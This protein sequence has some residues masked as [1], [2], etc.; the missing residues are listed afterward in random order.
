MSPGSIEPGKRADLVLI[1]NDDSPVMFPIVIRT[2]TWPSRL[3][4]ATCI[5]SWSTAGS[6][7]TSTAD[8]YPTCPPSGRAAE[9]TVSHLRAELGEAAWDTGMNPDIPATQILDNPYTYT[10]YKSAGMHEAG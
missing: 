8:R 9:K 5:P 6:S 7:S 10:E 1:K 3:S 4:A 2:V